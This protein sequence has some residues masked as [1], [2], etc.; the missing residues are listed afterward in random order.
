MYCYLVY[1]KETD[2]SRIELALR[3]L[4]P[5][6]NWNINETF[7]FN[8]LEVSIINKKSWQRS[9]IGRVLFQAHF[10]DGRHR[11]YWKMNFW[12]I[13]HTIRCNRSF[14]T[15]LMVANP[16][17]ILFMHYLW[18]I[19]SHICQHRHIKLTGNWLCC[20]ESSDV[21]DLV[22]ISTH[23]LLF[24][25]KIHQRHTLKTW[26]HEVNLSQRKNIFSYMWWIVHFF[27]FPHVSLSGLHCVH[28]HRRTYQ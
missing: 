13:G 16:F 26:K 23:Q 1:P 18:V 8:I 9:K 27:Q 15:I 3:I 21:K 5:G 11:P 7:G 12:W 10:Q 28:C 2:I 14:L 22:E 19:F 4:E 6:K 20:K 24:P 25:D 17:P